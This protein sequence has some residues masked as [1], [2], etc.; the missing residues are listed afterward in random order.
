MLH[1]LP[2]PRQV[3]HHDG[4][5]LLTHNMCIVMEN[6]G[7]LART[8]AKQL[9]E[10]IVAACGMRMDVRVGKARAGDI[11]LTIKPGE[12]AQGYTLAVRAE[13]VSV[14][15]QEYTGV[16]HGFMSF[17]GVAD[18]ADRAFAEVVKAVQVALK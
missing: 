9:Q 13:G 3:E 16:I 18:Q 15:L 12:S 10:E 14:H 7:T 11:C 6:G 5:F 8:G 4:A 17:I 1:L 2:V